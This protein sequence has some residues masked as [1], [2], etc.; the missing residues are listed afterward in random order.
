LQSVE[1]GQRVLVCYRQTIHTALQRD[2][3]N[4]VLRQ[5]GEQALLAAV[6][7][8]SV[9]QPVAREDAGRRAIDKQIG[10]EGL[11]VETS[12]QPPFMVNGL[13]RMAGFFP[14]VPTQVNFDLSFAPVNGQWR[15]FGISVSIGQSGP[16]AP[17]PPS[18]VA[19]K[20]P[21][22]STAKQPAP[23]KS[24]PAIKLTPPENKPA[25]KP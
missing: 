23:A 10:G 25:D 24:T 7:W 9:Q 15:L 13:M 16:I 14:S 19:Q 1:V 4:E 21:P 6:E 18:P 5:R 2:R 20:Q 3:A 17:E 8:R 12:R 22:A 11:G